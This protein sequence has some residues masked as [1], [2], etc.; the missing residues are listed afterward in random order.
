MPENKGPQRLDDIAE[1]CGIPVGS[2]RSLL[3]FHRRHGSRACYLCSTARNHRY[4]FKVYPE[5]HQSII[6]AVHMGYTL[7]AHDEIDALE[8]EPDTNR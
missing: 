5:G 2:L 3:H 4:I 1:A 8:G 6:D 7:E